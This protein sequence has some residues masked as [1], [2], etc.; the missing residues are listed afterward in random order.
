MR[1]RLQYWRALDKAGH[2]ATTPEP[3]DVVATLE[4]A[5]TKEIDRHLECRNGMTG[6][7]QVVS[8][9]P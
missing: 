1:R 2:A 9:T 3:F 4:A 5:R 8:A 6:R 7:V